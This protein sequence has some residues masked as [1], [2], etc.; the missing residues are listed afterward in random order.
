MSERENCGKIRNDT[1]RALIA[2]LNAVPE[3]RYCQVIVNALG[4][5]GV[6]QLFYVEDSE[7]RDALW[8]YASR[9]PEKE[10][11]DAS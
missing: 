1:L 10:S 4:L 8:A 11:N 3:Q 5:S 6:P 2:A 9:F 7:L